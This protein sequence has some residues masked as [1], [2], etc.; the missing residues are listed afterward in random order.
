M[1]CTGTCSTLAINYVTMSKHND[2]TASEAPYVIPGMTSKHHIQQDYYAARNAGSLPHSPEAIGS[3][4]QPLKNTC[5][6]LSQHE[7]LTTP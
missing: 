6:S 3:H 1:D 5:T 2:E 7:N 4:T